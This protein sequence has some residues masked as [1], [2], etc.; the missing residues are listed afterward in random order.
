MGIFRFFKKKTSTEEERQDFI[1]SVADKYFEGSLEKLHDDASKLIEITKF[2]LTLDEMSGMI[3]RCIVFR[4]LKGGWTEKTRNALRRDCS[5]KLSDIDLKWLLV[6]CD[7]HYIKK[8]K[9]EEIEI[10]CEQ[11]GRQIGMPSP[12]GDISANYQFK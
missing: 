6:Y 7:I 3:M 5:G 10:I 4:E 1:K 12:L 8:D 2:N 9:D 11:A